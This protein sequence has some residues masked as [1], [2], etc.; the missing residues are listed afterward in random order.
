M[1]ALIDAQVQSLNLFDYLLIIIKLVL[2]WG[3]VKK[4]V[5]ITNT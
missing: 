4:C 1:S 2:I 5:V 3:A